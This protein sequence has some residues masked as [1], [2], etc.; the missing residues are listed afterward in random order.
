MPE[1]EGLPA[2]LSLRKSRKSP[3]KKSKTSAKKKTSK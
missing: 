1:P 3:A 2:D